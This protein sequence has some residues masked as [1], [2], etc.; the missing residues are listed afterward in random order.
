MHPR[1]SWLTILLLLSACAGPLPDPDPKMAWVEL[2]ARE[3]TSLLMAERL[4]G[5][6]LDDGR[7][8]QVAPGAHDL[9]TIYRYYYG[10]TM[11]RNTLPLACLLRLRYP[12]FAAGQRY[13]LKVWA[14]GT[15]IQG[16]L[17][18]AAGQQLAEIEVLSCGFY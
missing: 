12:D 5:Q 4:D 14:Q 2:E 3:V 17:H 8:F 10:N 9:E 13:R 6:R 15:Q 1:L 7:Y 11:G 18:D 16:E